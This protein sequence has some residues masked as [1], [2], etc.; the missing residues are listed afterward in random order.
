M[1]KAKLGYED[2]YENVVA[3]QAKLDAEK[4]DKINAAIKEIE[5]EFAEKTQELAELFT[6][7]SVYAEPADEAPITDEAPVTSE[8]TTVEP[9]IAG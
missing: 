4:A 2:L 6:F 7:V 9:E 8:A 3:K 1:V 5:T